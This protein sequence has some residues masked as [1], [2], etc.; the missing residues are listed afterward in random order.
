MD[1]AGETSKE[2]GMESAKH[3]IRLVGI[4]TAIVMFFTFLRDW[5]IL[6]TGTYDPAGDEVK[7]SV[8]ASASKDVEWYD[9]VDL[10]VPMSHPMTNYTWLGFEL[11]PM[12]GAIGWFMR[13]R[14]ALLVS[15]GTFFTWFVVTPL[16]YYYDYPFDFPVTGTF[17]S[18]SQFD[19]TGSVYSYSYVARPMLSERF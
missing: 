2:G 19:P 3:S 16:A 17:Q 9:G 15:L 7:E 14:V 4:S 5:P 8:L 1:I 10:M 11:T 13:F 18:I 6:G 12:M